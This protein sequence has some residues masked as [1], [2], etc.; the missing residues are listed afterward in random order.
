MKRI[1]ILNLFLIS[2]KIL[3]QSSASYVP[4]L[5]KAP[6]TSDMERFGNIPVNLFTGGLDLQIPIFSSEKNNV[7][8]SY[9]S[10]GFIPS[11]KSNYVGYNWN[12]NY[13]GAITREIRGVADDLNSDDATFKGF[14]Y[15]AKNNPISNSSAYNNGYNYYFN[16]D[17]VNVG[18]RYCELK[19]DKFN[20]NFLGINGYFYIGNNGIP[21]ISSNTPN[22]KINLDNFIYQ[23]NSSC[24]PTPSG[25]SIIDGNGNEYYFGDNLN[26]M[27]VSYSLGHHLN[28]TQAGGLSPGGN[29]NYTIT[30]WY[31]YKVKFVD[32]E[33]LNITYKA[34]P[35]SFGS[36]K[37]FCTIL[38]FLPEKSGFTSFSNST[39][40]SIQPYYELYLSANQNNSTQ[41]T[42]SNGGSGSSFYT[43]APHYN[44]EVIKKVFPQSI[45]IP[46]KFYINFNYKIQPANITEN[47]DAYLLESI[48]VKNRSQNTFNIEKFDLKYNTSNKD[49]YFL[50]E[51][52]K[53]SSQKYVLNYN[54]S[55]TLPKF[56]T[57]GTDYWGFWNG[58]NETSNLLVPNFQLNF[59]T[60]DITITGTSRNANGSLFD[61]AL[62]K[63]IT[64]PTGGYSLFEYEPNYYTKR[65][66]GNS[67]TNFIRQLV[68]STDY[69]GGARIKKISSFDGVASL[70][71]EYKYIKDFSGNITNGISS[72]ILYNDYRMV[73]FIDLISGSSSL[74]RIS[75]HATNINT[76]T[77]SSYHIGY[78]EV[79]ELENNEL[80]KKYFFS[81]YAT[82][83]DSLAYTQGPQVLYTG[84][85]VNPSNYQQNYFLRYLDNKDNERGKLVREVFYK[86]GNNII[87]EN[88][89]TYSS[90]STH[91]LLSSNY[92]TF[93]ELPLAWRSSYKL[94]GW[95]YV[96]KKSVVK[97]YLNNLII[98]EKSTN[99]YDSNFHLN[100]TK[101]INEFRDNTINETIYTYPVNNSL[102][103][104]KNMVGLP[105]GTEIKQTR[106]GLTK[107]LSK[108]ETIYPSSI[109]TAQTGNLV[110]PTST[111]FYDLQN[112]A[113]SSTEVT[114]DQY[115][116]KGNL[117]QYTTK[118]GA[119]VTIIWGYH[120]TQPIAKIEGGLYADVAASAADIITASDNDASQTTN[121]DETALL[122]A[123]DTFRLKFPDFQITTYTYDPLIGVRSITPP[124]GVRA[125]YF[126][127][128]ANRLQSVKDGAG[129][130]LT[131]NQYNFKP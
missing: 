56:N 62:L 60:G 64:Y 21:V 106:N 18:G 71:K 74:R 12:L 25:F 75:E 81:D 35:R 116:S 101:K 27:E 90:L 36:S 49:Y 66:M 29:A 119:P 129:N 79:S 73:N 63:K 78:S 41:T 69:A 112:P 87:Q 23:Y 76:S 94:Y 7:T 128:S 96:L 117:Q 126:Y 65:V 111:L 30:G 130:I 107:I 44:I 14:L 51:I 68:S 34:K 17:Y 58:G 45:E 115:G 89:N 72:G 61:T 131:E 82:N 5:P 125:Y 2:L 28:P 26:N 32:G 4:T 95:P 88:L 77:L 93:V 31:L 120:Q 98:E 15:T 124:S 1:L 20:F 9:N 38:N 109:P 97:R 59:S 105:I 13:G 47:F 123:L 37:F 39:M 80:K 84:I 53:N 104:S 10:S 43:A 102:M 11:K 103:V 48:E 86:D 42:V 99:N 118:K 52:T 57:F 67:S 91:P 19:P 3:G 6:E 122:A 108:I 8:L 70:V 24:D 40:Q 54:L 121:N 92:V 22:L 110:L 85:S 113:T 127:D 55:T 16:L 83:P 46:N 114:Y 33:Q 50:T 100:P